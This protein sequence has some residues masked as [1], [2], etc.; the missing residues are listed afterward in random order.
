M[1][2]T[3]HGLL[4][5]YLDDALPPHGRAEVE[6]HLAQCVSCQHTLHTLRDNAAQ[7]AALLGPPASIPDPAAAWAR[8]K[9]RID[10]P[11]SPTPR[12]TTMHIRHWS[13]VSRSWLVAA[14]AALAILSLLIFPP[15]RAA[16]DRL[17]QVFRV[18]SVV[19][20]PIDPA[21]IA[22]L[23]ELDVDIPTLFAKEPEI[24]NSPAPPRE[25]GSVAEASQAVGFPVR[26]PATLPD[27]NADTTITV[28][29]RTTFS[30]QVNVDAMRQM[31]A[32]TGIEDATVPDALG[33][34]PI[35]I[36]IGAF[37]AQEYDGED[38]NVMLYQGRSPDVA[39]PDGVDLA[40]L[41]RTGLRVLGMS[42]AEADQVSKEIDWTS[43]LVVPIPPGVQ[44]A[45]PVTVNDRDGLLLGKTEDGE[46]GWLVY[47]QEGENFYVLETDG[48]IGDSE[49]LRIASS[50]R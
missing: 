9:H 41:G 30:L 6:A 40:T 12:R 45:R 39:L 32:L 2:C 1:V 5:A 4:R 34:A 38:W 15:V 14:S 27:A 26:A 29:D 13:R 50:V 49:V 42:E 23:Q 19:F 24:T 47:W 36:D 37:A 17:L 46:Q 8:L 43:T 7:V 18:R 33:D 21:R 44:E 22:Q 10:S 31:L 28:N 35:T 16:A 48:D 3:D 25:V 11:P 20:L